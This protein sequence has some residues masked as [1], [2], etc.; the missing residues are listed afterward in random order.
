M[1]N[2][3]QAFNASSIL[4]RELEHESTVMWLLKQLQSKLVQDNPQVAA[5]VLIALAGKSLIVHNSD[6]TG[7]GQQQL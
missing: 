3:L 6:V 7:R 5:Q 2:V 4:L 1:C